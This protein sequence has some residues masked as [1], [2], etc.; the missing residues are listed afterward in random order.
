[1]RV[2]SL[3][4]GIGGLDLGL[5]R[6]GMTVAWQSE[7]NPFSARVLAH[8]WPDTP[9]LGDIT[10]I[11]WRTVEPVDLICGGFPC[12]D[13][14][15]AGRQAGITGPRSGLW[16]HFADAIRELRP[17]FVLVENV[18]DLVVRGLDVVLGDLHALGFDAEWAVVPACS[19]GAPHMR[20]RLFIVAHANGGRRGGGEHDGQDGGS[21]LG[22]ALQRELRRGPGSQD[23][24]PRPDR[25]SLRG[26][27]DG[28]PDRVDRLRALGNAVVPAA[29]EYIG[30]AIISAASLQMQK[31]ASR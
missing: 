1:M 29:A 5:E 9:N 4:S 20:R 12:Q 14:S 3:F 23:W 25:S 15:Q 16:T 11:D 2:G 28:L 13:I 7:I 19:V 24:G 8:H 31:Q 17:R 18:G 27:D 22:E 21:V 6:A 30:R 26:V 10:T